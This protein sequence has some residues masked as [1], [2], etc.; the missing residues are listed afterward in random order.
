MRFGLR[1]KQICC[2]IH[3]EGLIQGTFKNEKFKP[4]KSH[5]MKTNLFKQVALAAMLVGA[6]TFTGCNKDDE[7]ETVNTSSMEQLTKDD[8]NIAST[9]EDAEN[10][11]NS[12]IVS[13]GNLKSTEGIPCGATLDSVVV[14]NDTISMYLTY[15]GYSCNG[16]RFRTGHT[17]V[18]KPVGTY[19]VEAGAQVKITFIDFAVTKVATQK[20]IILNGYKIQTNVS[21]G[22][23]ALL[24]NGFETIVH[25]SAGVMQTTFE[26]NTTRTWNIA[27][28]KTFTG[29]IDSLV[30][31]VDGYGTSGSYTNLTSWGINRAGEEFYSQVNQS[32]VFKT[33]CG[34]VPCSGIQVYQIPSVPKSATITY[35]YDDNNQLITNGDCPTKYRLDW[36]KNN[37]SGT[38]YL[39]L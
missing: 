9:T 27:R 10:E 35:G 29:T 6:L 8:D 39:F 17:I 31:A 20:T 23:I 13:G 2:V 32:V 34:W 26:D 21:G 36:Q 18:Q 3:S 37:L 22:H 33:Q 5:S 11:L 16:K 25:K 12:L 1:V 15:N 24:G 38:L 14:V 7:Q 30:M 4:K 28:Q 19:W